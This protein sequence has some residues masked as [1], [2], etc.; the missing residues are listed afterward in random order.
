MQ[1]FSGYE[2]GSLLWAYPDLEDCRKAMYQ[3]YT[4]REN[5]KNTR[6]QRSEI[7]HTQYNWD[8]TVKEGLD[9]LLTPKTPVIPRSKPKLSIAMITKNEAGFMVDGFNVFKSNLHILSKLADEIVVLDGNSTDETVKIAES[10]GARVFQYENCKQKCGLCGLQTPDNICDPNTREQKECFSKFR[11]ASFDLCT[12]DFILRIDADELIR[13]Q[14]IE[15]F[16]NLLA[17]AEKSFHKYIAF[18]FPTLN[19][20]KKTPYYRAGFDGSFSWF[21]DNHVRIYRNIPETHAF[22]APAHEGVNVPT[23]EGW[24]NLIQHK[25]ALFLSNPIIY[26]YGYLK[27]SSEDRNTRYRKMGAMTHYLGNE[28]VYNCS[29]VLYESAVPELRYHVSE[30]PNSST[31]GANGKNN[32]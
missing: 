16:K 11:K 9:T 3:V 15:T 14:D 5:I 2:D 6:K 21:P 1:G 17:N 24:K 18:V 13:E 29:T 31:G 32:G 10:F 19:F 27:K 12:G 30:N 28:N 7:I 26:H 23:E 4:D 20:W 25:Q 22:F 8:K